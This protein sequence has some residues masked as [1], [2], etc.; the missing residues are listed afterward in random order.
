M[1]GVDK[2]IH[3]HRSRGWAHG[4]LRLVP[5]RERGRVLGKEAGAW[6]RDT[7]CPCLSDTG[8]GVAGQAGGRG[9]GRRGGF[10]LIRL[11]AEG[12][13]RADKSADPQTGPPLRSARPQGH[14]TR[15]R[16]GTTWFL[17]RG[18]QW[19]SLGLLWVPPPP[20]YPGWGPSA[21]GVSAHPA[22]RPLGLT[23][24]EHMCPGITR[25]A[26]WASGDRAP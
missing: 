8:P 16:S 20:H 22:P 21:P 6:L 25:V 10:V 7:G 18:D 2:T 3:H 23:Q 15:R 1:G 17:P 4:E 14:S 5:G 12:V 24:A 13:L 26:R 9:G 19:S 11:P